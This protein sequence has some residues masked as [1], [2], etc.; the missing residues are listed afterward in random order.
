VTVKLPVIQYGDWTIVQRLMDRVVTELLRGAP[1][2]DLMTSDGLID[3]SQYTGLLVM[4]GVRPGPEPNFH[5]YMPWKL[6]GDALIA[7]RRDPAV[8]TPEEDAIFDA[9]LQAPWGVLGLLAGD[10]QS[11]LVP[12]QRHEPFLEAVLA[13]WPQLDEIGYRYSASDQP[14]PLWSVPNNLHYVLG[15][16]GV[17][18]DVLCAPLSPNG[19]RALLRYLR[20][21]N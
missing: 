16:L 19:P 5:C 7:R 1:L 14:R 4:S 21:A 9:S 20:P 3:T 8:P 15:Q 6:A 13:M 2:G 18:D 10:S 17:P 11:W 12:P